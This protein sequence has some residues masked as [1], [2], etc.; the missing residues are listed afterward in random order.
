M[1]ENTQDHLTSDDVVR[2]VPG[3]KADRLTE[4]LVSALK[5]ML[6]MAV[7]L[8]ADGLIKHDGGECNFWATEELCRPYC[9]ACGCIEAK[10]ANARAAIA[11]AT[12][13]SQADNASP[14][15]K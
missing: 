9:R 14:T 13:G 2:T 1:S 12:P 5:D 11:K 3:E 15:N 6:Y 10:I 7:E 4:D 8:T